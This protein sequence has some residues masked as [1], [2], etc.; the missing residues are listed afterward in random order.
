MDGCG[1]QR[2]QLAPGSR[3]RS[4]AGSRWFQQ[5]LVFPNTIGTPLEPRTLI[6]DFHQLIRASRFPKIR[7]HDLRHS[8]ATMLLVQGVPARVV[9]EILGHSG[10]SLTL[11]T[12]SHVIPGLR[13]EAAERMESLLAGA[14]S[15]RTR[16]SGS[17][18]E[19]DR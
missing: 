17:S 14:Q 13:R 7:F 6:R 11:D 18:R 3:A 16:P 8:C 15:E 9:M 2:R 10:I 1:L 19:L 4:V 5:G 12:Y